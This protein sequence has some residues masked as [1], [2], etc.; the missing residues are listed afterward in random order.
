MTITLN[1][2]IANPEACELLH[3]TMLCYLKYRDPSLYKLCSHQFAVGSPYRAFTLQRMLHDDY[4][5]EFSIELL[6]LKEELSK[7]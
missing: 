2:L 4:F 5:M 1:Q 3:N 7:D 6:S